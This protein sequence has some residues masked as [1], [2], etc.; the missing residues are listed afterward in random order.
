MHRSFRISPPVIVLLFAT[1]LFAQS[2]EYLPGI[3]WPEPPVVTPSDNGSDPPSDAIV[4][5]NGT[6]LAAWEGAENWKVEDGA[7][8]AGKGSIK[9]KQGFG[10]CQLHIEWSAPQPRPGQEGQGRGNSGIF[11]MD[12]YEL[13]V[14]DSYNSKTYPDGQ[15]GSIYKQTPPMVN[16]MRPPGEWNVYDVAWTAPRFAED[17]S[18]ESPARIT[19]F[20]NGVLIQNGFE[21][22]GPTAWDEPASYT[23]HDSKL[24]IQLQDHG[25]PVR[26]RN[27]WVREVAPIEGKQVKTPS[28]IDH[29]TGK[30]WN[31][32][33]KKPE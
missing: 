2:T 11:L 21:L 8:V 17:G 6:D 4:I 20:H 3:E 31:E 30:R 33:E 27:I 26:F 24:P 10:D 18:L 7:M 14:L 1:S 16:A 12:A 23:K 32:G 22:K 28:Y 29:A 13:Q 5:F 9:T 25:N 19:A 15:A